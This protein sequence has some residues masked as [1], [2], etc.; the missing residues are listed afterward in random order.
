MRRDESRLYEGAGATRCEWV[1]R[2]YCLT[3]GQT[4][5][6]NEW[7]RVRAFPVHFK[8]KPIHRGGAGPAAVFFNMQVAVFVRVLLG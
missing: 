2:H 5:M 4:I 3:T 7:R 8:W 1:V 6:N